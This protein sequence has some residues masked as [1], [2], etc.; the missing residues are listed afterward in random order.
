MSVKHDFLKTKILTVTMSI[1][2]CWL[3]S[4]FL[5]LIKFRKISDRIHLFHH[6]QS[7]YRNS[8]YIL[9]SGTIFS[10]VFKSIQAMGTFVPTLFYNYKFNSSAIPPKPFWHDAHRWQLWIPREH[11]SISKQLFW[12]FPVKNSVIFQILIICKNKSSLPVPITLKTFFTF[13]LKK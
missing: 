13:T 12:D 8:K 7:P 10:L 2:T 9:S 4:Y 3:G 11:S 1:S 6:Q 5:R